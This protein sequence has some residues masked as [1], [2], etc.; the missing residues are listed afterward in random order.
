MAT[1]PKKPKKTYAELT[2]RQRQLS[3]REMEAC[4]LVCEHLTIEEVAQVMGVTHRTAK[5]HLDTAR[6]KL[7]VPKL[8]Y[9]P[10]RLKELGL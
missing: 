6:F 7:D 9:I 1:K 2:A 4:R 10:H 5:H 8:R 3:P